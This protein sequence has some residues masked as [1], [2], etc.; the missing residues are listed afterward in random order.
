MKFLVGKEGRVLG[1]AFVEGQNSPWQIKVTVTAPF[2]S[3]C[4]GSPSTALG[5]EII[6]IWPSIKPRILS[7]TRVVSSAKETKLLSMVQ[8]F[9]YPLLNFC[10]GW[11]PVHL[12]QSPTLLASHSCEL[13]SLP[14][15][16][17]FSIVAMTTAIRETSSWG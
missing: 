6:Q 1:K 11:L 16:L 9:T 13:L 7:K 3:L 5:K 15:S 17:S 14:P 12:R 2:P 10:C 4:R 8:N